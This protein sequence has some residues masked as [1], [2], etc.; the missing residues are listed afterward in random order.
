MNIDVRHERMTEDGRRQADRSAANGGYAGIYNDK[1]YGIANIDR[2]ARIDGEGDL[3]FVHD[4][5]EDNEHPRAHAT[6]DEQWRSLIS[7]IDAAPEMLSVLRNILADLGCGEGLSAAEADVMRGSI[8]AVIAAAEPPR[9]VKHTVWVTVAVD[10]ET[11]PGEASKPGNV[12]MAAIEAV[13]DGEGD[14]VRDEIVET[15]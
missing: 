3:G 7:L 15:N 1:G 9:K 2:L 5:I 13:R 6:T 14:I 4:H 10:V 8:L 12:S 11:T